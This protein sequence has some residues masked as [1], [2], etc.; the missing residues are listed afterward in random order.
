MRYLIID[1]INDYSCNKLVESRKSDCI[2]SMIE[3]Y[4]NNTIDNKAE[5]LDANEKDFVLNSLNSYNDFQAFIIRVCEDNINSVLRLTTSINHKIIFFFSFNENLNNY[6]SKEMCKFYFNFNERENIDSNMFKFS[7]LLGAEFVKISNIGLTKKCSIDHIN[8]CMNV[9]IGNGCNRACSFCSIY[10]TDV[11]YHKLESVIGEIKE[12]LDNG[13]KSFHI[14]NH[15]FTSD[16]VYVKDFCNLLIKECENI[17]YKWSCFIIPEN[18][19]NDTDLLFLLKK[20][21]IDRIELGVENINSC[22]LSDFELKTQE[23]DIV[24]IVDA[25]QAAEISSIAINYIIGSPNESEE[26]LQKSKKFIEQLI[27]RT[28]GKIDINISFFYPDLETKYNDY[29]TIQERVSV[30]SKCTKRK[31]S[32][33]LNTKYLS[34]TDIYSW[35]W[36]FTKQI[37]NDRMHFIC[38][39]TPKERV[40]ICDLSQY[41][42]KT[43]VE[44]YFFRTSI[45]L[46]IEQKHMFAKRTARKIFFFFEE[47][48]SCIEFYTPRIVSESHVFVDN[49]NNMFIKQDQLFLFDKKRPPINISEFN[50]YK[51]MLSE[52]SIMKIFANNCKSCKDNDVRKKAI[53]NRLKEL[54]SVHLIYYIQILS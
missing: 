49:F 26:T 10:R 27:L 5:L 32:C 24:N 37:N 11:Q 2:A 17:P 28:S 53:I 8:K 51:S 44:K 12:N 39:L 38:K 40:N 1:N 22:I 20:A 46:L 13:I 23:D 4:I 47:I 30:I 33:L 14:N 6:F 15:A 18:I 21:K 42:I 52:L 45:P 35:N 3:S 29:R 36:N 9:N 43:Q 16:L 34:R 25:C 48:E 41:G 31:Q 19:V 50:L 54:E 7:E